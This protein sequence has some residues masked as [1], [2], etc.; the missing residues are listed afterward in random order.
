MFVLAGAECRAH[1]HPHCC[2]AQTRNKIHYDAGAVLDCFVQV[3]STMAPFCQAQVEF[4][5]ATRRRIDANPKRFFSEHDWREV[6]PN[7]SRRTP[8]TSQ[9][10]V[11]VSSFYVKPVAAFVPHLLLPNHMPCSVARIV[12]SRREWKLTAHM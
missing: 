8:C 9:K 11:D 3:N 7:G 2:A 4:I 5:K 12:R 1:K 6:L 10:L